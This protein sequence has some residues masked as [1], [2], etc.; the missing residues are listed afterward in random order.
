MLTNRNRIFVAIDEHSWEMGK[1]LGKSDEFACFVRM[2]F[3]CQNAFSLWECGY[4]ERMR[5]L[6][7]WTHFRIHFHQKNEHSISVSNIATQYTLKTDGL[8]NINSVPE[9]VYQKEFF[10]VVKTKTNRINLEKM[11]SQKNRPNPT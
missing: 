10:F 3:C 1:I 7:I 4:F 2:L 8:E 9:G 5:K 6:C 11:K